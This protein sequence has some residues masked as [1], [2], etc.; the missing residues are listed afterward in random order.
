MVV[1]VYDGVEDYEAEA[2]DC[3]SR[4]YIA[5]KKCRMLRSGV[6]LYARDEVPGELIERLPEASRSK[7]VF[8]VYR[9]PEAVVKHLKDFNY[10]PLVNGHPSV[11]ITPDNH[12]QYEIGRVGGQAT[13]SVLDDGN[14]YVENELIMDDRQAFAEYK[15]GKQELSIGLEAVWVVSDNADW[16]FE[17]VD[18]TNVNHLALVPRGRAGA[19]AKIT[20]TMAAVSRSIMLGGNSMN[21][22]LK[23]FGIG[24]NKDGAADFKLSKAVMDCAA[25]IA[26]SSTKPEDAEAE[27]TKVMGYV[28]RL[29]DSDDRKVLVGAVRDALTGAADLVSAEAEAKQKVADAIDGLYAK[30]QQADE[31][32]AKAAVDDVLK[33]CVDGKDK[34]KDGKDKDDGGKDK[35]KGDDKGAQKD[36]AEVIEAAIAKALDG[37]IEGLVDKAVKNA[38]GM[39]GGAGKTVTGQQTDG[40]PQFDEAD[41]IQNAWGL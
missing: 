12:K 19:L 20:D 6:Q 16:D 17:V 25:K 4:P 18:F 7:E 15:G 10:L 31:A 38:L 13:L 28:S 30:C 8:R 9:R 23:M 21:G 11:D 34:N 41:L 35:D 27:V 32:R 3:A 37:K 36:T 26:D 22:F 33:G 5:I 1:R 2:D 39:A 24:K 40:A 14:V 29:G